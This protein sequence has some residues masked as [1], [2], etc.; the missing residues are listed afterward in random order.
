MA[1]PKEL[2]IALVGC[3]YAAKIHARRL[4]AFPQVRLYFASRDRAKAEALAR[5]YRGAG[6]FGGYRDA[7]ADTRIDAVV[8]ATPPSSHLELTLA[9]LEAGKHCVVEKPPFLRA[10]DFDIVRAAKEQADRRV[11][12]AEN[13][14]Y[15]PLAVSL[16]R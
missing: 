13:Y 4:Q 6:S 1:D 7:I 2:G 15:K 8:V 5:K 16:R 9:A 12:V 14:F 10:A 11:L 3:G